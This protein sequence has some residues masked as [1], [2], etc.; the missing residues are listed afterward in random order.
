MFSY[1]TYDDEQEDTG[2]SSVTSDRTITTT[3]RAV[4]RLTT[5]TTRT[6]NRISVASGSSS[7]CEGYNRR[8]RQDNPYASGSRIDDLVK[9]GC[10]IIMA[11]NYCSDDLITPD[12]R[13]N[14]ANY[15]DS[16]I[17]TLSSERNRRLRQFSEMVWDKDSPGFCIEDARTARKYASSCRKWQNRLNEDAREAADYSAVS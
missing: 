7:G 11:Q 2:D 16:K 14:C 17:G 10:S 9:E 13:L 8:I 12:S 3:S 1:L 4:T 15:I 5:T 6:T